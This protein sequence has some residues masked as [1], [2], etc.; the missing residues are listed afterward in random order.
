MWPVEVA[1][2]AAKDFLE[3]LP[4]YQMG[5]LPVAAAEHRTRLS[6]AQHQTRLWQVQHPMNEEPQQM[7][8]PAQCQKSAGHAQGVAHYPFRG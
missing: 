7:P 8:L 5:L 1:W 2:K 6:Q 4:P 3:G